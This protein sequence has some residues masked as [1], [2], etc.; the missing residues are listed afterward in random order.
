MLLRILDYTELLKL[1]ELLNY[2]IIKVLLNWDLLNSAEVTCNMH[3]ESMRVAEK[4]S[5]NFTSTLW[6]VQT[7]KE[8]LKIKMKYNFEK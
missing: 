4:R 7:R 6:F 3:D 2:P 8:Y 5:K 1:L